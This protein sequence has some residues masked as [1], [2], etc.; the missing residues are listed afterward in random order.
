MHWSIRDNWILLAWTAA[1]GCLQAGCEWYP[2]FPQTGLPIQENSRR[3]TPEGLINQLHE[4][5][6]QQR[7]D[8]FEDLLPTDKTF[9]FYVSRR[10][11]EDPDRPNGILISERIDSGFAYIVPSEYYYWQHDNELQSHRNLFTNARSVRFSI[12]PLASPGDFRYHVD[13]GDTVGVEVLM[14]GGEIAVETWE[15]IDNITYI[16]E[17]LIEIDRQVFYLVRDANR[18]WVIKKWFDLGSSG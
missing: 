18:D 14:V 9:R 12:E 16:L 17:T 7:I 1:L 4:A 5:Y 2:F 11:L 6:E 8:L 10:F 3:K 15:V 13:G